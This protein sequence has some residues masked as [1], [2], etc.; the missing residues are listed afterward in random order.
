MNTTGKIITAAVVGLAA[1]AV[2]GMLMAPRSGKDT[3]HAL[4]GS[5]EKLAEKVRD[6]IEEGK[7]QLSA[8]RDNLE[9][10]IR[11]LNLQEEEVG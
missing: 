10:R 8:L 9:S 11:E 4:R 7:K 2:A 3:R 5:G 1:G 6:N